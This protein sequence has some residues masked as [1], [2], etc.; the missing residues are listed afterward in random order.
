MTEPHVTI[1]INVELVPFGHA[2][3]AKG[4]AHPDRF[5]EAAAG[6]VPTITPVMPLTSSVITPG[7]ARPVSA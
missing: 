2:S 6:Q 4:Y 7:H 1:A 5:D 3:A